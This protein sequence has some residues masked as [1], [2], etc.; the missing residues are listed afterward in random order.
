MDV[1]RFTENI[2][3]IFRR[4][5]RGKTISQQKTFEFDRTIISENKENGLQKFFSVNHFSK[6]ACVFLCSFSLLSL[7]PIKPLFSRWASRWVSRG[8]LRGGFRCVAGWVWV[9]GWQWGSFLVDCGGFGCVYFLLISFTLLQTHNVE[10]FLEHFPRVQINTEKQTFFCKSFAF[11]NILRQK[12]FYIETN[13]ANFLC[14]NKGLV[15]FQ[16]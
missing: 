14:E 9:A 15:D 1:K 6:H 11:V 2:F 8:G 5:L 3:I 16:N 7:S 13:G 12:M 10:Y 4:L